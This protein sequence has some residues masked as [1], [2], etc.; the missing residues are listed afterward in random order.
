MKFLDYLPAKQITNAGTFSFRGLIASKNVKKANR[1]LTFYSISRKMC[2]V[3]LCLHGVE[4]LMIRL[5]SGRSGAFPQRMGRNN[6]VRQ[7]FQDHE[8]PPRRPQGPAP[9]SGSDGVIRRIRS[10]AAG[11]LIAL[12]AASGLKATSSHHYSAPAQPVRVKAPAPTASVIVRPGES[13]WAIASRYNVDRPIQDSVQALIDA[14]H[15]D[16]SAKIIPGQKLVIP[17]TMLQ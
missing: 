11:L 16:A 1:R 2:V 14:N 10:I 7:G 15:L 3:N 4:N 9:I 12:S 6:D 8:L 17:A 13:L 5:E